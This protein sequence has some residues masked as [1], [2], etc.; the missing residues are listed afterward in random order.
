MRY[1]SR[2]ILAAWRSRCQ[3][4]AVRRQWDAKPR[5]KRV[6]SVWLVL[7]SLVGAQM[8]WVLRPFIGDPNQPFQFFRNR[9]ANIFMDVVRTI[10]DLFK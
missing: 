3:S 5:M 2:K 7:Y 9:E 1:D 4:P 8:G 6:L 10:E